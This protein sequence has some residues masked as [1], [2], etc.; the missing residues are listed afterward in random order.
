MSWYEGGSSFD[1][2]GGLEPGEQATWY[3]SPNLLSDLYKVPD[4]SDLKVEV[5]VTSVTFLGGKTILASVFDGKDAE[6]LEKAKKEMQALNPDVFATEQKDIEEK[7][8]RLQKHAENE[9]RNYLLSGR[10][11][12]G[13]C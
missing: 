4:R 8:I 1:I 11:T 12:R 9:V 3:L 2:V 5:D 13:E 10:Y 6:E 7:M